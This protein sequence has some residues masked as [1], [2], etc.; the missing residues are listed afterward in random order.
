MEVDFLELINVT[1]TAAEAMRNM[2]PGRALIK[3]VTSTR[4]QRGQCSLTR[5]PEYKPY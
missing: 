3:Q 2:K 4:G 5:P 1:R